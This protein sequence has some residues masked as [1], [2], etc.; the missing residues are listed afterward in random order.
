MKKTTAIFFIVLGLT[1]SV[2][3]GSSAVRFKHISLDEGLSQNSVYSIFQDSKGFMWFGT[4]DGLNKYDGYTFTVY[5]RDPD[6][7]NSLSSNQITAICEDQTGLLWIGTDDGLNRFNPKTETFYRYPVDADDPGCLNNGTITAL[8]PDRGGTLWIGVW[9]GGLSRLIRDSTGKDT[10]I[11]YRTIPGDPDSLSSD[12]VTSIL[13]DRHG[14]PW[15][16]TRN[17]GLN[18]LDKETGRFTHFLRRPSEPRSLSGNRVNKIYEDRLGTLWI[19]T[20]GAGLNLMDRQTGTFDHFRSPPG[21]PHV[22]GSDDI[23][24][25][26]EDQ[27]GVLWIG[28]RGRGLRRL[29]KRTG[30]FSRYGYM[31]DDPYSLSNNE[32]E[33]LY[34]D[35]SGILWVGTNGGGL[36]KFDREHKFEHFKPGPA[37][38]NGLSGHFVFAIREDSYGF[39]W[40]GI[41]GMG[42]NKL[43]RQTGTFT[44]YRRRPNDPRSLSSDR[45]GAIH[46]DRS[47]VLW[48]CTFGGG[49]NKFNRDTETFT[50]YMNHPQMPG[51][52]SS[53]EVRTIYEDRSGVLWIGTLMHGLN[54][55]NPETETFTRY[56][57]IPG[58]PGSLS[59]NSI[60][61]LY[62]APSEPGVLWIGTKF[63][64]LNRFDTRDETFRHFLPKPG[65]IHSISDKYV[66]AVLEDR[67]GTIWVGTLGGGLNKMIRTDDKEITFIHYTEKNG[68]CNNSVYGILED[69]EGYLW[70]STNN[71]LSRFNPGTGTFKNYNARDGLQGNE[72]NEGAYYKSKS[73]EMFFG[74]INGFN[75]FFPSRM[76]TNLHIPPVVLTA[77]SLFNKPVSIGLESSGSPLQ[78]TVTWAK[79]ICLSYKQN[80]FSFEFAALDY[81]VPE[82]NRYSYK[83]EGLEKDWNYTGYRKRFAHYTNMAPGE[84]VFHVKGSNND[85]VWNEEGTSIRIIIRPPFWQTI[86]FRFLLLILVLGLV[87]LWYRRRLRN[88]RFKTELQ[89]ARSAQMSIL[90]QE[91]PEVEGFDISGICVPASEVGGDFFD[92]IW[93]DEEKTKL[94]IAVGDVSGKA[95]KSAMTA[96]MTSGIIYSNA[97]DYNSVNS[98]KEIMKRVNRPLYFKTEKNVFTALCMASLDIPKKKITFTNAGLTEPMLKSGDTV[99]TLKS[100]G[101]RLPLGLRVDSTYLEKKQ[102]LKSGDVVVFFTDGVTDAKNPRDEFYGIDTLKRL[103]EK[104]ELSGLTAKGI[105]ETIIADADG[106]IDGA[107]QHDDMTVVVVKVN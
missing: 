34:E 46:E 88:V 49:L 23:S 3:Q 45:I 16:G 18:R 61:T 11:H 42:L 65:D 28:S 52:L 104:T 41:N 81:T 15:I 83:M 14:V 51:T 70:L 17:N 31:A 39:L 33:S 79:E 98:I 72:F 58:N 27:S 73:G 2:L 89:T 55:F 94:G 36:N 69:S 9:E 95:M 26:C 5:K 82:N 99:S 105:I 29:D 74:G 37:G 76:K 40:I 66:Q 93:L 87:F 43:D 102:Q 54:K 60:R 91:D 96:V 35:R 75:A 59:G 63:G 97:G 7:L 19:G 64:G 1:V 78:T 71:G 101:N 4:Q 38:V 24:S 68:L 107:P 30:T 8:Y 80:A 25:I 12:E 50:R 67:T 86:W 48:V 100:A 21:A 56:P 92:Y 77:F 44:H 103:L 47:G 53:N 106:F 57:A 90:P 6:D 85:W 13:V 84:Y 10:F 20:A 32:V 62:E 22:P